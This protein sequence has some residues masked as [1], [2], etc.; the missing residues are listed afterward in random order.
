MCEVS[1]GFASG[2]EKHAMW[3]F[4]ERAGKGYRFSLGAS[5]MQRSAA[6]RIKAGLW[7]IAV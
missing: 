4:E 7:R 5:W 3:Q 6:A 1:P 2:T